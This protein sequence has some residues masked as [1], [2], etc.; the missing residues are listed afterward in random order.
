[1]TKSCILAAVDLVHK[2]SDTHVMEEAILLARTHG[3]DIEVVFVV[4]DQVY[5]YAQEYIPSDMR[6][7][8]EVDAA[9]DLA[10]YADSFDWQGVGHSTKVLR[11]VVY[12]KLIERA[13]VLKAKFVVVGASKPSVKDLLIGPNAAR[14]SRNASCSVLVVR[15][16]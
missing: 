7:Q 4:P 16:Q 12:E 11:G 1:M 6:Q 5:S 9:R 14:V 15:P 10:A 8:V 2:D 13:D 3:H